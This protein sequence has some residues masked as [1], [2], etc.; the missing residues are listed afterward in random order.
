MW[1]KRRSG[2]SPDFARAGADQEKRHCR[3]NGGR[4]F[5]NFAKV[6]AYRYGPSG[7]QT[8]NPTKTLA[9]AENACAAWL[10]AQ[11]IQF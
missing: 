6:A 1:R 7:C 3:V 4:N 9:S 8:F 5:E 10:V 2:Q 11:S